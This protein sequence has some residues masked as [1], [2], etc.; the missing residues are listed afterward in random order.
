VA[1]V[2]GT[3]ETAHTAQC[4]ALGHADL[5]CWGE[6]SAPPA[7][8]PPP[9]DLIEDDDGAPLPPELQHDSAAYAAVRDALDPLLIRAT[10]L[11]A[12]E[13]DDTL[14]EAV[15]A[16][17]RALTPVLWPWL[18]QNDHGTP[19]RLAAVLRIHRRSIHRA[20]CVHDF[21][22]WPCQTA[23]AAGVPEEAPHA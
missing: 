1:A 23:R 7:S 14:T 13:V 20:N 9:R 6:C 16:T 12:P 17:M 15:D 5:I 8:Q 18:P 10:G 11:P 21:E 19:A 4:V 3:P 22:K 2:T